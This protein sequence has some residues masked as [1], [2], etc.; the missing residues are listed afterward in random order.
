[1]FKVELEEPGIM[2]TQCAP[3]KI[4]IKYAKYINRCS[5]LSYVMPTQ[6]GIHGHHSPDWS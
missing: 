5:K 3:H 1:M 6:V 2:P 4:A